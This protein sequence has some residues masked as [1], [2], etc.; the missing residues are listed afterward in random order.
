MKTQDDPGLFRRISHRVHGARPPSRENSSSVKTLAAIDIG[1]NSMKLLVA[2]VEEDGSL[3]VLSREKAMVRL[4][5]D[6]LVLGRLSKLIDLALPALGGDRHRSVFH[7]RTDQL[8][9][10]SRA[11]CWLVLRRR[12]TALGRFSS[13]VMAWRAISSARSGLI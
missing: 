13:R 3:E 6:A 10:I 9:D 12:A 2:A 8:R 11:V 1:T 5:S 7:E 4:G